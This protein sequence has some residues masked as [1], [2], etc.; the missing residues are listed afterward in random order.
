M[1]KTKRIDTTAANAIADGLAL[2]YELKNEAEEIV[3]GASGTGRASTLFV[4]AMEENMGQLDLPDLDIP[5]EAEDVKVFYMEELPTK[6]WGR[7][8]LSR[9]K[10][11]NNAVNM[12]QAAYDALCNYDS[13]DGE[14]SDQEEIFGDIVSELEQAIE[15]AESTEW[16][17]MRG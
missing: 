11:R 4:L 12:L 3:D 6:S 9:E 1:H 16:P 2:L 8:H 7:L 10:R 17:S 13:P 14:E 5:G 15:C